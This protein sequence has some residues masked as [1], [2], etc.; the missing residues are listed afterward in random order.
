MAAHSESSYTARWLLAAVLVFAA[1]MMIVFRA[2]EQTGDSLE[3]VQSARAGTQ[4]FHPHHLL[5]N[6]LIR[7]CW[8]G[9][10]LL[11]PSIDPITSGQVHNIF[12][13]LV[14]LACVFVL[15]HRMTASAAAAAFFT[16]AVFATVGV[17]RYATLIEVYIPSMACFALVLVLLYR[18]PEPYS[19]GFQAAVV[20]L[21]SLAILYDQMAIFFIIALAILWTPRF[22]GREV[23]KTIGLVA[24]IGAIVLGAYVS[25][26]LTTGGP[27]TPAG[28]LHWCLAY[29][30]NPDPSWGSWNNVSLIGMS[31]EFLSFAQNVIF[32]PRTVL[33]PIAVLSGL[34]CGM[35]TFFIV[36]SLLRRKAETNFR[37][38]MFFWLLATALF[39]WWFSPGGEELSIPLLLPVL[40]LIVR[41]L[42]DAWESSSDPARARRRISAA[43]V[44]V[45]AVVFAI[46]L[47][48][49]V[50]PAHASRGEAYE[51]AALLQ[52]RAPAEA[53]IFTDFETAENLEYYFHRTRAINA[54]P[55]LFSFYESRELEP[56]MIPDGSRP[57]LASVENLHPGKMPAG[58]FGGDA[59]PGEWRTFIEWICGCEIMDGRVIAARMPSAVPGLPE[60]LLLSGERRPMDGLADLFQRLDETAASVAPSFAGS[61]S[62]WLKRHPEQAR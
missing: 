18:R 30:Y 58:I 11:F 5:F 27:K 42:S 8:K 13:A 21:A 62:S 12:W 60:C 10:G 33:I 4:L 6:P 26:F 9:L 24:A 47:V 22:G 38:A 40:L 45:G 20:V 31:K 49:A 37:A 55:V 51:R 59:R 56:A 44:V 48:G 46:N 2:S 36:R 3:Y 16:L 19:F 52:K 1:A 34:I 32:V 41:L 61:F 28:F 17:W 15:I 50:G 14:L 43:A 23:R 29:A 53:V 57:I 25:A 35:L 7:L 39:M 54:L